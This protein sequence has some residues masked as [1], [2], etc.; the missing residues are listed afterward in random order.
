MRSMRVPRPL[1]ALG[2]APVLFLAFACAPVD[3]SSTACRATAIGS[4]S[5]AISIGRPLGTA[6]ISPSWAITSSA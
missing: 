2:M 5:A 6:N 3:D 4:V 1:L